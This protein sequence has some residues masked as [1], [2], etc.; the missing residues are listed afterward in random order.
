MYRAKFKAVL[1]D[2]DGTLLDTAPDFTTATNKLLLQNNLTE[3]EEE[4]IRQLISDGSAGIVSSIF[5]IKSNHPLYEK[6]RQDL[7]D[8]YSQYLTDKTAPFDGIIELLQG[9]DKINV[10]WGIVTNK[11]EIYTKAILKE[12]DYILSPKIVVC[13][14]HVKHTKP[15][16]EPILL[17]CKELGVKP[18]NTVYIGDHIRDIQAGSSAGAS[19]IAA[20]YGYTEENEDISK[21][22]ANFIARQS[23]DLLKLILG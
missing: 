12:F 16:P 2:L 21:W 11:P 3:I 19:T 14:D 4:K 13:P 18:K 5:N 7:L 10:P 9:L 15:D 20:A 8:Y 22:N 1:F 17:A 6:T 23:R